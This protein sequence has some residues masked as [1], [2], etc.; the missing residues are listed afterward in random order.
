MDASLWIG[1]LS[2]ENNSLFLFV[3][4]QVRKKTADTSSYSTVQTHL[5]YCIQLTLLH[6]FQHPNYLAQRCRYL[7]TALNNAMSKYSVKAW[8]FRKY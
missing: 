1:A 3:K 8:L 5:K 2:W 6:C 4:L 7:F